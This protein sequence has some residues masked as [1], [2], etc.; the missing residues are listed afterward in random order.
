MALNAAARMPD[1][2]TPNVP[3]PCAPLTDVLLGAQRHAGPGW[4]ARRDRRSRIL[5]AA[6]LLMARSS[7]EDVHLQEVA[8]H[9]GI[10]VPTIYN[11]IG[12][13]AEMMQASAEEWVT[14]IAAVARGEADAR[15]E[16][17]IYTMLSMCWRSALTEAD[18]VG[19]AVRSNLTSAAPLKRS[20]LIAGAR[21]HL[22]DLTRLRAADAVRDG[23]DIAILAR[24]L[25]VQSYAT[26]CNFAADQYAVED[27]RRE[28]ACGPGL[29]LL[30][31]L[32]GE[33]LVR[34]ERQIAATGV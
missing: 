28:L 16:N 8:A 29:M 20:F 33:Q 6:R 12:R 13:R 31:A 19:S 2:P 24:Q 18:Y 4:I 22:A 30:G 11:I 32:R 5:A 7:L 10:T 26:I 25:S 34:V 27:F 15:G 14:A 1:W 23:V 3:D 17:P 21:E 9:C